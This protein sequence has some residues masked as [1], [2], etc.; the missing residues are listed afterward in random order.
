M[1]G[2]SMAEAA[3]RGG[4]NIETIR[5]YERHGLLPKPPRTA[6]GYRVFSDNA[7]KQLR[8]I[9]HAQELGFSLKEIKDLLS[10]RVRPGSSCADVR[11]KTES[12]MADVDMKIRRLQAIKQALSKL[13]ATCVGEG[14]VSACSILEAL[15]EGS[16]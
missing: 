10:L 3:E 12:K 16:F 15:D 1:D 9:K 8:F 7:V 2:L 5:Y 13:T 14:P 11:R 6:S 4:V